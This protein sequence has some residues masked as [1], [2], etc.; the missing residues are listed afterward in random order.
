MLVLKQKTKNKAL[1]L[2]K[3]IEN[4]QSFVFLNVYF[5]VLFIA[6]ECRMCI[7]CD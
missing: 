2:T 3:V 4:H 6:V 5:P 7:V 1:I